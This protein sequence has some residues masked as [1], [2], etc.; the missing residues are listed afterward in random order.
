MIIPKSLRVSSVLVGALL[1]SCI[2]NVELKGAEAEPHPQH[3][4]ESQVV[5]QPESGGLIADE[6]NR[7]NATI[8][9]IVDLPDD[10]RIIA[11]T[12][13]A[14]DDVQWDFI[15]SVRMDG[16][17]A[18]VSTDAAV[19]ERGRRI[20]VETSAWFD[21]LYQNVDL[22]HTIKEFCEAHPDLQ[23]EDAR[24]RDNPALLRR[25]TVLFQDTGSADHFVNYVIAHASYDGDTDRFEL[26]VDP[27]GPDPSGFFPEGQIEASLVPRTVRL[28]TSGIMDAYPENNA[29]ILEYDATLVDQVTGLPSEALSYSKA[30]GDLLTEDLEDLNSSNWDFFRFQVIFDLDIGGVGVHP[31]SP[32]PAV[33]HLRVQFE[34]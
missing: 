10:Q 16:F 13:T 28:E 14:V 29:V 34:F 32:R 17:L 7:A 24:Y 33:D 8:Q 18:A 19:R 25:A 21:E 30:N 3:E 31:T 26:W 12:L 1:S 15:Q 23:G 9:A 11:N 5:A 6:V 27:S 4:T 22:Y 20:Q 2:F